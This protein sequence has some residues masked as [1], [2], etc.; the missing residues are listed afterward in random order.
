[1]TDSYHS[2]LVDSTPVES[3]VGSEALNR[4]RFRNLLL[5][6]IGL[7]CTYIAAGI[8]ADNSRMR[9]EWDRFDPIVRPLAFHLLVLFALTIWNYTELYRFKVSA[10][11]I[12]LGIT[13]MWVLTILGFGL[14]DGTEAESPV[15]QTI[16]EVNSLLWGALLAM[17]HLKPFSSLFRH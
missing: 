10:P 7:S 17:M 8:S 4:S 12:A 6:S 13:V 9:E 15:A 11:K 1:M 3:N 14:A 16:S 5:L 2:S